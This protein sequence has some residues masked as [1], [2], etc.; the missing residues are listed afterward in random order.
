MGIVRSL[1][2]IPRRQV[3]KDLANSL[4]KNG[5][6][7]RRMMGIITSS[8]KMPDLHMERTKNNKATNLIVKLCING[9][10]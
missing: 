9:I 4:T 8:I 3:A 2:L 6:K 1:T 5:R 10:T 7:A